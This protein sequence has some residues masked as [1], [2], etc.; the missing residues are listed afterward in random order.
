MTSSDLLSEYHKGG[1]EDLGDQRKYELA[2]RMP[3]RAITMTN[4]SEIQVKAR[5]PLSFELRPFARSVWTYSRPQARAFELVMPG[6]GGQLLVNLFEEELRHWTAP[7]ALGRR[8]GPMG[9]QGALTRPVIIDTA[10]RQAGSGPGERAAKRYLEPA[11]EAPGPNHLVTRRGSVPSSTSAR[12][13]SLIASLSASSPRRT[14][15]PRSSR[16]MPV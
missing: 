12:C 10:K 13:A 16:V 11:A 15:I 5:P 2:Q 1:V 9:L 6:G 7:E 3:E 14:H 8:I 4:R